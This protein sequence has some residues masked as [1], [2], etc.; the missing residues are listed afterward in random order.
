VYGSFS[1]TLKEEKNMPKASKKGNESTVNASDMNLADLYDQIDAERQTKGTGHTPVTAEQIRE[2]RD[3]LFEAGKD[4]ISVATLRTLID[5]KFGL[6]KTD[7]MDTRVQ[8]SSVRSAA[9]TGDFKIENIDNVAY[10]VRK[11]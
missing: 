2:V 7:E 6:E 11:A 9:G 8:N 3:A 4:Q 5:K 10:I 1:R